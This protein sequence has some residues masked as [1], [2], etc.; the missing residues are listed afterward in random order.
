MQAEGAS[1][2][3]DLGLSLNYAPG[4]FVMPSFDPEVHTTDEAIG[5]SLNPGQKIPLPN[6]NR[7]S[8]SEHYFN[9]L[10]L[11]TLVSP[12]FRTIA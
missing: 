3:G 8:L 7:A 12:T 10:F 6:R 5:D 11:A 4:L 2:A 9:E 1:Q